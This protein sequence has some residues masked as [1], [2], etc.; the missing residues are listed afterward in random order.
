ME[1]RHWAEQQLLLF[2]QGA[3]SSPGKALL[4]FRVGH[5]LGLG[6]GGA[7]PWEDKHMF[8][9][10]AS[11]RTKFSVWT[12]A[13]QCSVP[14][15]LLDLPWP[16][17]PKKDGLLIQSSSLLSI[18]YVLGTIQALGIHTVVNLTETLLTFL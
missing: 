13:P 7:V 16:S 3:S 4:P 1:R 12:K 5:G 10:G 15:I 9:V 17:S 6:W 8:P 18:Y 14:G 11:P 2:L